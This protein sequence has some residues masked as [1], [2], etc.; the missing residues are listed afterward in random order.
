MSVIE[1]IILFQKKFDG[2]AKGR[3]NDFTK[4]KYA[5]LEDVMNAALPVLDDVGLSIV[6][7]LEVRS[8]GTQVLSTII[9]DSYDCDLN[10]AVKSEMNIDKMCPKPDA[11]RI[12][13]AV[14]YA[15]RYSLCSLLNILTYDDDGNDAV[16]V[17]DS[18]CAK[19]QLVKINNLINETNT[20]LSKVILHIKTKGWG[21]SLESISYKQAATI[22]GMLEGKK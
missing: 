12:G 6:Q 17:P 19:D 13:S 15:R 10:A 2:V 21:D 1:K 18:K 7:P 8:D 22:I 16:K 4:S 14:T 20:D 11:Q 9:L 5:N 3:Q